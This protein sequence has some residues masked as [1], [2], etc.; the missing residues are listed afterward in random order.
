MTGIKGIFELLLS[1][2]IA[3]KIAMSSNI[4]MPKE[5]YSQRDQEYILLPVNNLCYCL[6]KFVFS[7]VVISTFSLLFFFIFFLFVLYL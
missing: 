4:Q 7:E 2:D 5:T 6:L 1:E 3:V